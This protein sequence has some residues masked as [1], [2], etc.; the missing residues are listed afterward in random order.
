MT[1]ARKPAIIVHGHFY[2]PPRENPWTGR[3][4]AEPSAAP[5][6]DW[7]ARI[8]R[9]CYLPN[10]KLG[11]LRFLS[12]NFGP[13]LLA[14]ADQAYPELAAEVA[15]AD[16]EAVRFTGHGSAM[17]QL[18]SHPIAPLLTARDRRTQVRWGIADFERRYGRR[19][20]GMWLPECGVDLPSLRSLVDEG[21]R[22]TILSAHQALRF[23]D[24][25]DADTPWVP[26]G[27]GGI[28]TSRPAAVDLGDGRSI[29]VFFYNRAASQELSF[30]DTLV[31]PE[32]LVDSLKRAGLAAGAGGLVLVAT[33]GE[34]F[35]HHK[36]GGEATL[37]AAIAR[38][39]QDPD[40]RWTTPE[41]FLAEEPL[42][43]RVEIRERTAWSCAHGLG[44]WTL[45]CGCRLGGTQQEWRAPLREAMDWLTEELHRIFDREGSEVLTDPWETRDL[46]GGLPSAPLSRDERFLASLRDRDDVRGR[47]KALRLL[48]MER[49]VLFTHTSC[50]WFFDDIGGLEPVQNLRSAARALDLSGHR[51]ALEPRF[52]AILE[53]AVSND[54]KLGS[55]AAIYDRQVL[56]AAFDPPKAAGAAFLEWLGAGDGGAPGRLVDFG[57]VIDPLSFDRLSVGRR[58][59]ATGVC[60]VA[61]IYDGAPETFA[62]AALDLGDGER[63]AYT[64]DSIE[65]SRLCSEARAEFTKGRLPAFLRFLE[66]AFARAFV[67]GGP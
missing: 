1:A 5:D 7:N 6:H 10:V 59:L 28:D 38:L 16:R 50:G 11:N 45:N 33:D 43:R 52:K 44:R 30:G 32:Y 27:E 66:A 58:T 4:E 60:S 67:H 64:G 63:F 25:L 54:P 8:A 20:V 29:A 36:K 56:T 24:G 35:G 31:K 40:V 41:A 39:A 19:P 62:V 47:R 46:S 15:A 18:F 9:E 23:R 53:R 13:T 37:A 12:F 14:W 17:A 2:Q 26:V 61:D 21:I 65:A 42:T 49:Q 48:E 34:T 3:V 57:F 22:F 51:R 55:G